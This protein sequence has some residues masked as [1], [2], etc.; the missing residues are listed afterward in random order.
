MSPALS[1]GQQPGRKDA[2]ARC[3][4]ERDERA[5][6]DLPRD[7]A[8]RLVAELKRVAGHTFANAAGI[9]AYRPCASGF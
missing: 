1:P 7:P 6:F 4:R 9:P 3:D 5:P 8:Q 2:D